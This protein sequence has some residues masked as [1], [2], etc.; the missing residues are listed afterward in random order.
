MQRSNPESSQAST[1]IDNDLQNRILSLERRMDVM[2]K[3]K[4]EDEEWKVEDME[5]KHQVEERLQT[6]GI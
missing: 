4:L 2:E 1:G 5:W 3:W 6:A